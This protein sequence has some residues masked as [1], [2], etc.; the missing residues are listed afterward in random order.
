MIGQGRDSHRPLQGVGQPAPL[1]PPHEEPELACGGDGDDAV[2]GN[3]GNDTLTGGDGT[4]PWPDLVAA[5]EEVQKRFLAAFESFDEARA[6]EKGPYSPGGN[7]DETL[8]SLLALVA[9]HQAY[10]LGQIGLAR[11][12]AGEE[13]ALK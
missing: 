8:G 13:G 7:P 3:D 10:H 9:F 5:W 4:L 11:R 6:A 1:V 12:L 2:F